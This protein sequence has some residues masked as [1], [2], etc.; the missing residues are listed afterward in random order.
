MTEW[1]GKYDFL[2]VKSLTAGD[3]EGTGV[4]SYSNSIGFSIWLPLLGGGY[5]LRMGM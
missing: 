4:D 3:F 1:A 2:G 5:Y